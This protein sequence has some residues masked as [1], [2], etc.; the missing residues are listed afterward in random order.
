[1]SDR[2]IEK[3]RPKSAD[4]GDPQEQHPLND[5]LRRELQGLYR[6]ACGEPLPDDIAELAARLEEKL[7][8]ANGRN[9]APE[10]ARGPR[11]GKKQS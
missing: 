1:M 8:A 7:K 2:A 11:D 5:W 9:E 6:E 3:D 4:A 10:K